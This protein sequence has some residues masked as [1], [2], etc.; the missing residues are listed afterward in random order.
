MS[1]LLS[2]RAAMGFDEYCMEY[3]QAHRAGKL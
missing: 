2:A 3:I 1:T